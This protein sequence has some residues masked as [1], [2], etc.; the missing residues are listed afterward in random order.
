M[1]TKKEA[2]EDLE[3]A[4]HYLKKLH[5]AFYKDIP[6]QVK[7]RYEAVLADFNKAEKGN[8]SCDRYSLLLSRLLTHRYK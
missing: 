2:E 7:Q 3:Y 1:L 6:A 5:P 4:M 8:L